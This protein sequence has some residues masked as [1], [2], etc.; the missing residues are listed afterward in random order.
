MAATP[1]E[2]VVTP[3]PEGMD[4]RQLT[5]WGKDVPLTDEFLEQLSLTERMDASRDNSTPGAVNLK[6]RQLLLSI[7]DVCKDGNAANT[8]FAIQTPTQS[9]GVLVR[10][11][12]VR[13]LPADQVSVLSE[14]KPTMECQ[15]GILLSGLVTA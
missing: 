5:S 7:G 9:K 13:A 8:V 6:V 14:C 3:V 12:G 2:R 10:V 1:T 4:P 15:T 11:C